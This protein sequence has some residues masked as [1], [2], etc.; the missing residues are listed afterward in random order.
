MGKLPVPAEPEDAR[1]PLSLPISVSFPWVPRARPVS[2]PLD[3]CDLAGGGGGE[4]KCTWT[5]EFGSSFLVFNIHCPCSIL[6]D[7]WP[8]PPPQVPGQSSLLSPQ[9]RFGGGGGGGRL[10]GWVSGHQAITAEPA[11]APRQPGVPLLA[12]PEV[13][14]GCRQ[15]RPRTGPWPQHNP[16]GLSSVNMEGVPRQ[17]PTDWHSVSP[18][19]LRQGDMGCWGGGTRGP[20][21]GQAA[22]PSTSR[23]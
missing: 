7:F 5:S 4:L 20:I 11:T 8:V 2:P 6:R 1:S 23:I 22:G 12:Q 21:Q 16:R 3:H 17:R 19:S 14:L 13:R 15:G 10:A 18:P 9:P